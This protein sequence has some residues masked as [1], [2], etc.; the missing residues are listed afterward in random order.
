[1]LETVP[2]EADHVTATFDVLVTTAVNCVDAPEATVAVVGATVTAT[3]A[4]TVRVKDLDEVCFGD[5][6]SV[7]STV[8]AKE[9]LCEVV[10]EID[11]ADCIVIPVGREPEESDQE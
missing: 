2:G 4:V 1:V 7:T 3:A 10:P 6:E 9:P 5:E 8:I 11:P